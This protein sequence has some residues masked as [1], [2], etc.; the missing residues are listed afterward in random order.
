MSALVETINVEFGLSNIV[1]RW[2][3]A[4]SRKANLESLV[5]LAQQYEQHCQ[6]SHAWR[7]RHGIPRLC[8][9]R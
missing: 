7:I 1:S 6:E 9:I 2:G 4:P 5:A 8:G 3:D